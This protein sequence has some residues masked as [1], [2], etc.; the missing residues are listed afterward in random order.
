MRGSPALEPLVLVLAS[1]AT[2]TRLCWPADRGRTTRM[3]PKSGYH[4]PRVGSNTFRA[5]RPMPLQPAASRRRL[6][7]PVGRVRIGVPSP[8][9]RRRAGLCETRC[10]EKGFAEGSTDPPS[11]GRRLTN[12]EPSSRLD[13]LQRHPETAWRHAPQQHL[14]RSHKLE[15]WRVSID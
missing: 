11:A 4:A 13:V 15:R 7:R 1:S 9:S 3:V 10:R 12:P 2:R 5:P 14:T 6:T 8:V